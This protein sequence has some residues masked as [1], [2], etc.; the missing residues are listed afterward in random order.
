[1]FR[2]SKLLEVALSPGHLPWPWV[3]FSPDRTAFAFPVSARS[4]AIRAASTLDRETRVDLPDAL[5]IPTVEAS[6]SGTTSRQPGLHALALHPDG[7]TVVA[8]GW[9]R[10][11]PAACVARPGAAPE[12]VDL[13]PAAGERGPMAATFTRDGE[14]IWVSCESSAGAALVRLRFRDFAVEGTVAFPA[15]PPPAAHEIF[16]HPVEDAVL[17]T[18]A[19]GEDGTF[20]RVARWGG[21]RL[22]LAPGKGDVGLESCGVA[23]AT[24]D[25]SQVCLVLFDHVELRR[26]PDLAPASSVEVG[27]DQQA[28]YCGVRARSRFIVSTTTEDELEDERALVFDEALARKD[29]APAPPGMWAGLLGAD[30]LVTIARGKGEPRALFVYAIEV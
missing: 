25:G 9:H 4:V 2:C 14:S 24:D 27:E 30:R 29:D 5:G 16:L 17:L 20:T 8:F 11:L 23:G 6:R 7:R 15:A 28:N 22:E 3:S 12:L 13:G 18:M 19:C 21:D 26:W 10:D 1:M